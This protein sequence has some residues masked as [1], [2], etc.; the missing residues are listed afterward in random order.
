MIYYYHF[1]EEWSPY[2]DTMV[3]Y[4]Y[5]SEEIAVQRLIENGY[6]FNEN[7]D[8]YINDWSA[9]DIVGIKQYREAIK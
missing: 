4:Y 8:C 7:E 2:M 5:D 9:V 3:G 1:R 6:K